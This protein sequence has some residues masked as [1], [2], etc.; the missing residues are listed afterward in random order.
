MRVRARQVNLAEA[1]DSIREF[2]GNPDQVL[3]SP[4]KEYEVHAVAVFKGQVFMLFVND[5]DYPNWKP[6]WLFDVVDSAIPTDW[7]CSTFHDEPSLVLGPDFI[8]GSVEEYNA[9]AELEPEQVERFWRRVK[10]SDGGRQ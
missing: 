8:A 2:L 5:L 7:I 3:V 1:P 9:M 4:G 6:A 10:S